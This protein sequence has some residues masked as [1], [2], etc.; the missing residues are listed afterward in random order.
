M[1][2]VTATAPAAVRNSVR[3]TIVSSTYA[4][5]EVEASRVRMLQEPPGSPRMRA[6][7]AGESKL[8]RHAQ[9]IDPLRLTRADPWQ[10]ESNP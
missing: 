5:V 8:G 6:N 4:R 1:K 3:R 9:S 2:S 10:F 7:M